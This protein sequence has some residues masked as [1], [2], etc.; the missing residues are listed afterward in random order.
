MKRKGKNGHWQCDEEVQ[1]VEEKAFGKKELKKL[2]EALPRL[3]ECASE[4]I[5]RLYKEKTGVGCYGFHPQIPLDLTNE[6]RRE[7]VE[8]LE[9]VEQSG[10]WPRQACTT[11]LF[12]D[13]EECQ[14]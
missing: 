3:K 4:K 7:I 6:T 9:K 13:S 8:S 2:E 14:K 12:F 11:M 10:K 1:N 5:S